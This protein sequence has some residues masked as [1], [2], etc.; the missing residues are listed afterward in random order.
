MPADN[1]DSV[2]AQGIDLVLPV[3]RR[4]QPLKEA[5]RAEEARRNLVCAGESVARAYDLGRI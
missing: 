1:L 5:L 3:C 4:P 2:Y